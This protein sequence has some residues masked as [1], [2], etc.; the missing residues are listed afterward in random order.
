MAEVEQSRDRPPQPLY[1][2]GGR[3]LAKHPVLSLSYLVA[4]G[5]FS[6]A[7]YNPALIPGA[8]ASPTPETTAVGATST[9]DKTPIPTQTAILVPMIT[10]VPLSEPR[11]RTPTPTLTRASVENTKIALK[12]VSSP[13]P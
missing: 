9:P 1:I 8:G 13:Q 2:R 6:M 7:L 3:W 5:A 10:R 12:A 11:L 4:L